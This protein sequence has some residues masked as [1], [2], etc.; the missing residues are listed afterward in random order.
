MYLVAVNLYAMNFEELNIYWVM[1]GLSMIV[2]LSYSFNYISQLTRV[3]SV[4]LLIATGVI[5]SLFLEEEI[6]N[7]KTFLEILGAVGLIMIVL[8][9]SLDLELKKEKAGL[10]FKAVYSSLILLVSNAVIIAFLII[11]FFDTTFV[12]SLLYAVP[13]SIMSS[14]IIIPSVQHLDEHKKEFLIYESAFSDIFGIMFFYF[15]LDFVSLEGDSQFAVHV[16]S[17]IFVTVVVSFILGY[18]IILLIQKVT[19]EVKLF[20]PIATLI[21]LYAVGK[22][23]HLSSLIFILTFGLMINNRDIFFRGKLASLFNAGSFRETLEDLKMLTLESSF[24]VRTFFFI[25]FGMSITAEGFNDPVVYVVGIG[26]LLVMFGSRFGLLSMVSKQEKFPAIYIA[27]RGLITILL[28]F[29]IP[30]E[31]MLEGFRP[32]ILLLVILGSNFLMTYGLMKFK[33][34]MGDDGDELSP[35]GEQPINHEMERTSPPLDPPIRDQ[36]G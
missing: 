29:G 35:A 34:G 24:I 22:L 19:A 7:L 32:A 33:P 6:P 21:L 10:I 36:G 23:F 3:P 5:V 28:F 12:I 25:V 31:L 17:N 18:L 8:E 20:L 4:L 13:L 15:I 11:V 9:A 16:V 2:I 27:P 1:I 26:S 14:A 30:D